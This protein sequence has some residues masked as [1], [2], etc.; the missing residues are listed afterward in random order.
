MKK[1]AVKQHEKNSSADPSS[2][3]ANNGDYSVDTIEEP[4]M[5]L[6]EQEVTISAIKP[7]SMDSHSPQAVQRKYK[8]SD[9]ANSHQQ[10]KSDMEGFRSNLAANKGSIGKLRISSEMKAKLEQLTADQTVRSTKKENGREKLARSMEDIRET[11]VNKLSEHRKAMLENQLMGSMMTLSDVHR[12]KSV[13]KPPEKPIP[14]SG[15][16]VANPN[17]SAISPRS[18]RHSPGQPPKVPSS[19]AMS[20]S[21]GGGHDRESVSKFKERFSASRRS[22]SRESRERRDELGP[23]NRSNTL[24][25][26]IQGEC[27]GD[28]LSHSLG[29]TYL[30]QMSIQGSQYEES[31]V[32]SISHAKMSPSMSHRSHTSSTHHHSPRN[33]HHHSNSHHRPESH[34]RSPR[35]G[36]PPPPP[37][38]MRTYMG[39]DTTSDHHQRIS[40]GPPSVTASSCYAPGTPIIIRRKDQPPPPPPHG[41]S[42]GGNSDRYRISDRLSLDRMEFIE[43][44]EF[45]KPLDYSLPPT[46]DRKEH[47]KES[48]SKAKLSSSLH[49]YSLT[50]SK[51]PWQLRLRKEV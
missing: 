51:V 27:D 48:K 22:G 18:S 36:P 47:R 5:I 3:V 20:P 50:Y 43:S 6:E 7:A 40:S 41:P 44:N 25:S 26:T 35:R 24:S 13:Q 34:S 30:D 12:N 31:V 17:T 16:P 39:N 37:M 29:G 45:L 23:H 32:S 2:S 11:R 38:D 4:P 42:S 15:P 33:H 9:K 1:Q 8:K 19:S 10:A 14:S 21:R 28:N 46:I 49:N